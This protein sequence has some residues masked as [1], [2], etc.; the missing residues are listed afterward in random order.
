M[1]NVGNRFCLKDK[2]RK[3]VFAWDVWLVYGPEATWIDASP[4][5]PTLFMRQ[6]W[7][8]PDIPTYDFLDSEKLAAHVAPP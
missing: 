4:P 1:V 8:Q 5:K 6:L 7:A 2:Q 3:A